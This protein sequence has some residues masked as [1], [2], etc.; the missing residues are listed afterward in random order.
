MYILVR[1]RKTSQKLKSPKVTV[2]KKMH[3][4]ATFEENRVKK[5]GNFNLKKGKMGIF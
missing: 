1:A 3:I 2:I 4:V 5:A